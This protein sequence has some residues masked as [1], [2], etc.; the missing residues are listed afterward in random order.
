M[1]LSNCQSPE[2]NTGKKV[3]GERGK[4]KDLF[5]DLRAQEAR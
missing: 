2:N 4:L 3:L 5:L 1:V